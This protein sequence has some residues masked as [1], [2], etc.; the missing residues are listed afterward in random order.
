[1]FFFKKIGKKSPIYCCFF[2]FIVDFFGKNAPQRRVLHTFDFSVEKSVISDFFFVKN[3]RFYQ[4]F[5]DFPSNQL[6][7]AKIFSVSVDNRFF[8]DISA[9]KSDFFIHGNFCTVPHLF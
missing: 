7:V 9:E 1:M 3:R 8:S 5:N 2:Q 6:S 4:F